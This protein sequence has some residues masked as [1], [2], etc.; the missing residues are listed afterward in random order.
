[1]EV[2]YDK[3]K[4][5]FLF[6]DVVASERQNLF[7][8]KLQLCS[9]TFDFTDATANV[10][11]KEIKRQ[12]L[13]ELVDYVNQGQGKFTEVVFEDISYMLA[14]NLFRGLPPSNHEIT[15]SAAG[16]NFDPEEEEPTLEPSWPHLQIV[17]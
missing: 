9:Y 14:Q 15:G 13:L 1:M 7:V 5:L 16:D 17:Y 10:R 4:P 12:T 2:L 3:N 11:E 6:R 8:K